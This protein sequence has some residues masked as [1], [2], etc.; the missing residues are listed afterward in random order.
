M[1]SNLPVSLAESKRESDLATDGPKPPRLVD[2]ERLRQRAAEARAMAETFKDPAVKK[3]M[4]DIADT[5]DRLADGAEW[6]R[7]RSPTTEK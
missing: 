6:Q 5:Y 4:L 3:G 2:Q 7:A 1:R